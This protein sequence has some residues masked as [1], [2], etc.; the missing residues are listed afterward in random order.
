[1]AAGV[2]V[3]PAAHRSRHPHENVQTAN[4]P[5]AVVRRAASGAG[6]PAP[7]VQRS[8]VLSQPVEAL[9]QPDDERVECLRRGGGC[10]S[11]GRA[12]TRARRPR[13]P[14]ASAVPTSSGTA[15]KQHRGGAADPVG[16][17]PRQRFVL[18]HLAADL[19]AQARRRSRDRG[20]WSHSIPRR[21]LPRQR[22]P[23]L[24][25]ADV[26]RP[27]PQRDDGV[28]GGGGRRQGRGVRAPGAGARRGG[29]GSRPA[30]VSLPSGRVDQQLHIARQDAGRSRWAGPRAP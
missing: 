3:D 13:A 1:M 23:F 4:Q 20:R 17:V 28:A 30:G 24:Q 7:T 11:R 16:G 21:H 14:A 8:P 18:A 5:A 10:W 27:A 26:A 6:S 2:H 9:A 12:R 25:G 22:V 29:G 19:A 15:G